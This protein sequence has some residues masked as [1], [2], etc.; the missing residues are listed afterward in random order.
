MESAPDQAPEQVVLA[1]ATDWD[2]LRQA[3]RSLWAR[4]VP[5]DAV[6]WHSADA[7]ATHGDLFANHPAP[8]RVAAD[9]ATA[10]RRAAQVPPAFAALCRLVLLHASPERFGL[11]YR[12][13]WRLQ[14]EPALRH[15]PLDADRRRAQQLA[16]EVRR[17]LHKM[18]AFV[19]FRPLDDGPPHLHDGAGPLHV[20][21]FMPGHHIVDAVA[22]FFAR[23]FATMRWAILTPCRSVRWYPAAPHGPQGPLLPPGA[24]ALQA[25]AP[26]ADSQGVLAFGP[27]MP[28]DAAPPADAGEALWLTY[29][30]HI[31][32]PARLKPQAMQREMPRKYWQQLPEARLIAPLMEQ[33]HQ[34]TSRMLEQGGPGAA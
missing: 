24:V 1:H 30:A 14:H 27:G 7:L 19:R 6:A 10:P 25:M 13:V 32:N 23:R 21:S 9:S 20:A 2:G 31:F 26:W 33:A 15:D 16:R 11:I 5:P 12:L 3:V 22:P 28:A 4:G 18:K 17:D 29:Y 8:H 34:R